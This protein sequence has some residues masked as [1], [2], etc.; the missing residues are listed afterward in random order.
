MQLADYALIANSVPD[1]V[2]IMSPQDIEQQ[3][4]TIASL[5]LSNQARK[6]ENSTAQAGIDR[7]ALLKAAIQANARPD[8]SGRVV[9]DHDGVISTLAQKDAQLASEY[10]QHHNEQELLKSKSLYDRYSQQIG[11]VAQLA[12]GVMSQPEQARPQAYQS[13]LAQAKQ[14]GID[15]TGAPPQ[16]DQN[17]LTGIINQAV[18]VK[19]HFEADQAKELEALKAKNHAV[20]GEGDNVFLNT[21]DGYLAANKRTGATKIL[22]NPETGKPY[23]AS[24]ADVDLASRKTDAEQ[25]AKGRSQNY[26]D[27][28]DQGI[29]AAQSLPGL[30]RAYDLQKA[31]S[32]GGG[33]DAIRRAANYLGIQSADEGELNSLLGQSIL[34]SLKT[35]FGGNP[36]E[37]EREALKELNASFKNSGKVNERILQHALDLAKLRVD[38]GKSAAKSAG[39]NGSLD[40]IEKLSSFSYDDQGGSGK[41]AMT[42]AVTPTVSNW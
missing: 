40:A 23:I 32:T 19:D 28:I 37:G 15:V 39:D 18:S 2:K 4:Q 29:S 7:S 1:N 12:Q 36:T 20:N 22:I 30:R 13:A 25:N 5:A 35:T 16:Y 34:S 10:E 3:K 17:Y 8:Q 31:I 41:E 38:L 24:G 14:L 27:R 11:Q 21:P 26:A 42:P 6:I 33:Q 9:V